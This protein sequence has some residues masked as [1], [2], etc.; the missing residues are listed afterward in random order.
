M[1]ECRLLYVVVSLQVLGWM[2]V[3]AG[4]VITY[5]RR[6]RKI[7]PRIKPEY[8]FGPAFVILVLGTVI[9]FI[10]FPFLR[11]KHGLSFT[12]MVSGT[13]DCRKTGVISDVLKKMPVEY[14]VLV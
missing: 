2:S 12:K 8:I 7:N 6:K 11:A 13:R 5:L 4:I 1:M 9:G 10:R 14:G 3:G